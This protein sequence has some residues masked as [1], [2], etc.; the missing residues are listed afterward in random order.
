MFEPA[1]VLMKTQSLCPRCGAEAISAVANGNP[2]DI[3]RNHP[4][5]IEA[6]I[7]EANGQIFIHKRCERHGEFEDLL[8]S[9]STFFKRMERLAIFPERE[10]RPNEP[11]HDHGMMR[12]QYGTGT[13]IIFDLTNRC[14]MRCEP[15]FM[16]ANAGQGVHELSFF[17]IKAILDRAASVPNRREV[18]FLFSGGEPT[19][20]PY[21]LET[22]AYARQL[23]FR[24]LHVATNGIRFAQEPDLA[25]TAKAAGLHGVFLQ[26]DG[27]TDASNAHR[28]LM[29]F[30]EVK[31]R[32]IENVS[33]AGLQLTLQ[34]TV[35]KGWNADQV[36]PLVQ[37]AVKR[38]LFSVL[39]QPIMFAGR[40][41]GVEEESRHAR[42]Y[43]M[44]QLTDDLRRQV[45]WDWQP[46]RDWYPS[47]CFALF[48]Y[49]A[50]RLL[51]SRTSLVC[52]SAPIQSIG[53]PLVVHSRTG[54][55]MALGAF[56][57]I[58][59]FLGDLRGFIDQG[60]EGFELM[61][62]LQNAMDSRF[63]E[64]AAPREFSRADLYRLLEQCIARVNSSIEG[65]SDRVYEAGP[66]RLLIIK[67][68]WF[69]DSYNRKGKFRSAL[70]TP[71][72][73]GKQSSGLTARLRSASGTESMGDI[74][75]LP[76]ISWYPWAP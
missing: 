9:D 60:I 42:R 65:W 6:K 19:L 24:R 58:E 47:S 68:A 2:P 7:V 71:P 50:D 21:F 57:D 61:A 23:G 74:R 54:D 14:N 73:G 31:T 38:G 29:N 67:A 49:L 69:Q 8:A 51:G 20:S 52:T 16:D 55:V 63:A 15:C 27:V 28:G 59:G 48:G 32:A 34:V 5:V 3:L 10:Y 41:R 62:A 39:F 26:I 72:A 56:F 22:L 37:F 13:F 53:S 12:V 44:S 46:L 64:A 17:D 33:A 45:R 25:K 43:T 30:M 66:W 35:V 40:D 1:S 18:N 75:S 11:I 36:G 76:I 4:G 70:T